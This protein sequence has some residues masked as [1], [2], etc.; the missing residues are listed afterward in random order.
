MQRVP[1][2][3]GSRSLIHLCTDSPG[4]LAT[5]VFPG[6]PQ[7]GKGKPGL[8]FRPFVQFL[9]RK[10]A[11]DCESGAL[12]ASPSWASNIVAILGKS[13]SPSVSQLISK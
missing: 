5:R 12:D 13:L 8:V 7:G 10:G 11:L 3:R 1:E 9:H 6:Q 4:R 2:R